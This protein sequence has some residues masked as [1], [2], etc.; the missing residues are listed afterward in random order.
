M[1]VHQN[2]DSL[3]HTFFKKE[4]WARVVKSAS[5]ILIVLSIFYLTDAIMEI[6]ASTIYVCNILLDV[7]AALFLLLAGWLGQRAGTSTNVAIGYLRIIVIY[8]V[9]T[10]LMTLCFFLYY[11]LSGIDSDEDPDGITDLPIVTLLLVQLCVDISICPMY[12]IWAHKLFYWSKKHDHMKAIASLTLI[13]T[14][15]ATH[16]TSRPAMEMP[17]LSPNNT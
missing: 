1:E 5:L 16:F 9:I 7:W 12:I 10:T 4:I 13:P 3:N 11:M 2:N 15:E 17:L 14:F 8:A 6:T